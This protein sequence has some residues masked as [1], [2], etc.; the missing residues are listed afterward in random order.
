MDWVLI[1]FGLILGITIGIVLAHTLPVGGKR[2][3]ASAPDDR[4]SAVEGLWPERVRRAARELRAV[5]DG[6]D[7]PELLAEDPR[8]D[9]AAADLA[10]VAPDAAAVGVLLADHDPVVSCLAG[11]SLARRHDRDAIATH[12]LD[13]LGEVRPWTFHFALRHL[14]ESERPSIAALLAHAPQWWSENGGLLDSIRRF[15]DR[16]LARHEVPV[17]GAELD[18]LTMERA[19][20]IDAILRALAHAPLEPL[21]RELEAWRTKGADAEFLAS[22]GKV[23]G[24]SEANTLV[25]PSPELDRHRD[26]ILERLRR[27]PPRSVLLV[28]DPGVGKTVLAR[29]VGLALRAEGWTVLEANATS[30]LAE[31]TFMGSLE[32]R[33]R[34][35]LAILDPERR[36]LWYAPAF[37]ELLAAGRHMQNPSTGVIDMILPALE[38][39]RLV[40]L[41]EV[42]ARAYEP[43][44][45]ARPHLAS[46]I[47]IVRV[48]RSDEATTLALAES[49]AATAAGGGVAPEV[50]QEAWA[51]ARHYLGELA[52]PGNLLGLLELTRR[53]REAREIEAPLGLDDILD[54]LSALSGLP[55][56]ILDDRER[57]DLDA[58]REHLRRAVVGQ[59]EAVE[60][61]VERVA[62]IKAGLTDPDRPLAVF[63][64]V[65]PTGTGKTELAKALAAFL[66][67]SPRRMVRLDMSEFQDPQ[68][69]DRI[70]GESR[71]LA[72]P[73]SLASVVRREPFSVVLLD[74]FEK[75]HERVWDLFLQVFDDG[76][77]TD[78][79]GNTVDF[80]HTIILLTSNLGA[81]QGGAAPIG[82][83]EDGRGFSP[84]EVR[85]AVQQ[86]FSPEF[87]NRLDRVVVF[88]PLNRSVMR[89]ILHK[90]LRA[91]LERRGLRS[92]EWAVEWEDSAIEFLLERGF[93]SELGARPLK[94]A[95]D[96]HV[97]A[98]LSELIVEH[99][100][101]AGDQF[102]FLRSDGHAIQ[103]E[104]VDPDAPDPEAAPEPVAEEAAPAATALRLAGVALAPRGTADE[105]R[106][107]ESTYER[108]AALVGSERWHARKRDALE[109]TRR[110]GFWESDARHAVL[111]D[112]E[113]LDRIEAAL[114]SARSIAQRLRGT[115]RAPRPRYP[116]GMLGRL[117]EQLYLVDAASRARDEARPQDALLVVE[118]FADPQL[119]AD[120]NEAFARRLAGM[121]RAWAR[122]RRM[123][124]SE[125]DAGGLGPS[126]VA[127]LAVSGLGAFVILEPE[128]G[129]HVLECPGADRAISRARARVRVLPQ[130]ELRSVS[131]RPALDGLR[132][133]LASAD[134]PSP[135]VVR[136]YRESPS[137]LVRDHVR[138][139]R[140][141]RLDRVLEGDFDLVG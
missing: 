139:W 92:R 40:L 125:I 60:C 56:S 116:R 6:I 15:V 100:F 102:L 89:E 126:T 99:R 35:L 48:A 67:G 28:G 21:A 43:L 52:P 127:A 103:A 72:G 49:W 54:T 4:A 93:T 1:G 137:P 68:S 82:F 140:T 129:L 39:G 123:R 86:T 20:N 74:E 16:R 136:H 76:R 118:A 135:T 19:E 94:R 44:A 8:F 17:F 131:G 63:L 31:Q 83:V 113:L 84:A 22:V 65:G 41:G 66:F 120:T 59:V 10:R 36:V 109:A 108:L 7:H 30:L 79:L 47:E 45:A 69:L 27:S 112:I 95:I 34:R 114:R 87:L 124:L 115:A 5:Y 32:G 58:V 138:G 101:P 26:A 14:A 96:R 25:L 78:R 18:G 38:Q 24:D 55:R 117:A 3:A 119:P 97:L 107:L 51:L 104:F 29:A 85:R 53:H 70:L 134:D 37:H 46:A 42:R 64:L 130:P 11:E 62:M 12:F 121:Y 91:S 132:A 61:I 13:R 9:A 106:L 141:G 71:E 23:W 57:L 73:S 105:L 128:S 88:E 90:E 2:A 110:D 50:L 33:M 111:E 122:R 75:A 81:A 77:L 98:P 133:A 80:R